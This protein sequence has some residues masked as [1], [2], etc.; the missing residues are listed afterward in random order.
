MWIIDGK[1]CCAH[2][3]PFRIAST[4][5][6][7]AD[8]A[9]ARDL[10][11]GFIDNS[12]V[13][14]TVHLIDSEH[15]LKNKHAGSHQEIVL[16]PTPSTDPDDPLNWTPRRKYLALTCMCIY[17]WFNGI[18]PSVVYSVI[19]SLANNLNLTVGDIN[20]GTGYIYLMVGWGLLFWQP[21]ALQYGKRPTYI[22][23]TLGVMAFTMWAPY[24]QNNGQWI[25]RCILA[26]FFG[27][28]VDALPEI[29]VADLFFAHE[30]GTY[31]GVYAFVLAG[32]NFF[33]PIICGFIN[34]SMGYKWVFYFPSIFL[35]CA[36]VFMFFF[37]EETNYDRQ[38]IDTS[39][40][41]PPTTQPASA[42]RS[43]NDEKPSDLT[44]PATTSSS[45]ESATTPTP[46]KTYLQKLSLKDNP[47]P[48]RMPYRFLLSLRLLTWPVIIYAGFSYGS[49]VIWFNVLNATSSIILGG[50]PYNFSPAMVGLSYLSPLLGVVAGSLFTGY[51]SDWYSLKLARRNG[52]VMEPEMRLWGFA[53]TTVVVPASLILWGVGA[54]HH[55]HWFGL[56]VGMFGVSFGNTAGITLSVTYLVDSYRDISG[57]GITPV[58]IIRNTM[59]FAISYG[60]TP[61]LDNLGTQDCFISAAFISLAA[62]LVFLVMIWKG[63]YFRERHRERYWK[64]VR[65]H[66]EMGMVH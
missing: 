64:L 11:H 39:T 51:C 25:A 10:Q 48:Q 13:P 1:V 23:S 61:W 40:S 30:R 3:E 43:L 27:A 65:E 37:M 32:S 31:M 47:R 35:G 12:K 28:P 63:K 58:L 21:L 66:V 44:A 26:G 50:S 19:T 55:V 7:A 45:L 22:V 60:I 36:A 52:G 41:S 5:T 15:T 18:A 33:A 46:R 9:T 24:A 62:S 38:R 4:A 42:P 14:G 2:S 17:V 53:L 56:L 57:D 6:M 16:V 34:D 8:L 20:S 54:A 29:T 59:S 49:Y